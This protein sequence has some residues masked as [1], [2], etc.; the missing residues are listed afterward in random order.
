MHLTSTRGHQPLAGIA[1]SPS[2]RLIASLI[3]GID[4]MLPVDTPTGSHSRPYVN[5]IIAAKV[6]SYP[7]TIHSDKKKMIELMWISII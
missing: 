5:L 1:R 4:N 2:V 6:V 7:I 3:F